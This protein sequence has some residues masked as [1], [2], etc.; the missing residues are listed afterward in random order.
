MKVEDKFSSWIDVLSS[1][2][3]GSVLGG[4]LFDI[5]IDDIRQVV[6]EALILMFADDTKVALRIENEEDARKMQT[7]I[8]N[9]VRWAKR[10]GMAFNEAKCKIMHMGANNRKTKYFMNGNE[11]EVATEEKD[12]GVWVSATMKPSKQC[13]VAAKNANFA[14]GQMLR[15]FHYRKK[16][17]LIPLYKCF[18]RPKLEFAVAA[19][20]PWTENDKK[21]LERVQERMLRQLCDV[22]GGTYEE[23]LK[24]AGLTTLTAR[25]ERGDAIEA[26]KT[27]KG[28]NHVKKEKWFEFEN[29]DQR[30]TRRNTEVT[31]EGERRRS[32]VLR[33]EKARLEVRKQF[34][35]V[36]AAKTWNRIPESVREKTSVNSFKNAYDKW[37]EMQEEKTQNLLA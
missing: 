11:I 4:T 6:M 2:V 30:P 19:W 34:F 21:V 7:I 13:S 23:R 28:F 3:Q 1:V 33:E 31:E 17:Q 32:N 9:L 8:D 5:F 25:R 35:N 10:W 37:K 16:S 36:R 24:D 27:I 14:L 18:V 22:R 15:A 29:E 20:C 26:F 12:L